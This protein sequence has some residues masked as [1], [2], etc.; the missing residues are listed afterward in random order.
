MNK[1]TQL[2]PSGLFSELRRRKVYPVIAAYAVVVWIVLQIGEVTFEPLGFPSWAMTGL[3][4]LAIL[5]FPAVIVLSWMFDLSSIGLKR[6]IAVGSSGAVATIA[7]LPFVD[8]SVDRDQ[9][10]FCDGIAEEIL[11]ALT[12]IQKLN[13][14]ARMSSFR[15][16]NVGDDLK[17]IGKELGATAILEGSVR[18][19]DHR[20]RIGA[21]L[22]NV[23]DGYQFWSKSF[24]REL[25][26]IFAIQDDIASSIAGSLLQK[27]MPVK[28]T[29]SQDVEAYEYYLRGRQF[30]HR[31]R[32]KDLDY[33]RRMFHRAIEIDPDFALAWSG[34]ADCFS[35]ASMY[36]DP[37]P[38]YRDEATS[39][40]EKALKLE[41]ELAEAHAS[42]GLAHLMSQE[43]E[44]AE[45]EFEK[46]IEL[47]PRLYEA[48]YYYGRTRFHQGN[49]ESAAEFFRKAAE[50]NAEDFQSRFLRV[51]ILRGLGRLDE[52]LVEARR[53]IAAV[54]K[55]LEWNPDDARTLLLGTGSLLLMGDTE[56]AEEWIERALAIDPTDSVS[57]YNAACNY[58]TIGRIDAAL[59]HLERAIDNGTV[60]ADWMRN[61]PDLDNLRGDPRYA[62]LLRRA[63]DA[64]ASI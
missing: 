35:L 23:N 34:Y 7:V 32:K 44:N 28:T 46:A 37:E 51:Q 9:G 50:V 16:R 52:A 49:V 12:K 17:R 6:D 55:H 14:V 13:V 31:F 22:V 39:A 56:R 3:I 41:P 54:E 10:Y 21:Q 60:S 25:E 1:R 61:D 64:P 19:S 8:M 27:L 62:A 53:G 2:S 59:D 30:L 40:S 57:L 48:Y 18:K 20:L 63:E 24:D 29:S 5:G 42:R 26:D 11:N 15:Y 36:E 4:I 43:F 45:Q 33:A 38:G 47:N 58:A